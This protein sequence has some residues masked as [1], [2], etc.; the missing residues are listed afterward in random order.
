MQIHRTSST[1]FFND[2]NIA[3]R[4]KSEIKLQQK[5]W[6]QIVNNK[7]AFTCTPHFI[8]RFMFDLY[9]MQVA[10]F[11]EMKSNFILKNWHFSELMVCGINF[12]VD[13]ED[14]VHNSIGQPVV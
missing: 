8:W 5:D 10:F 12:V 4:A 3:A 2:R 7:N 1:Y 14:N 9:R 6:A 11:L 13:Y